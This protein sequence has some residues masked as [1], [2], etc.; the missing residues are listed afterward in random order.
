MFSSRLINTTIGM[1]AA[2]VIAVFAAPHLAELWNQNVRGMDCANFVGL[3]F[4]FLL[5]IGLRTKRK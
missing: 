3:L 5:F 2:V 4:F 1:L